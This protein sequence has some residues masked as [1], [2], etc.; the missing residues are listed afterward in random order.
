M[1]VVSESQA[2]VII[3]PPDSTVPERFTDTY[4]SPERLQEELSTMDPVE[5]E[6]F[7]DFLFGFYHGVRKEAAALSH[8]RQE[9]Y[10][11]GRLKL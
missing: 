1:K 6:T 8:V 2:K 9:L 3:L 7:R 5:E 11:E 4:P 10:Q